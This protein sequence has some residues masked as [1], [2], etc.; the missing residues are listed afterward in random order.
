MLCYSIFGPANSFAAPCPPYNPHNLSVRDFDGDGCADAIDNCQYVYNPL[1][2]DTDPG[3]GGDACDSYGG[4]PNPVT[5]SFTESPGAGTVIYERID[6]CFAL[7][8]EIL[9]ADK[10]TKKVAD[11]RSGDMVWNPLL[12]KAAQVKKV[13]RGPEPIPLYHIKTAH[14]SLSVTKSHPFVTSEGI[15][16]TEHLKVGNKV[17]D[18]DGSFAKVTSV[19][20]LPVVDGQLVMNFELESDSNDV[21]HHAIVANGIVTGDLFLQTGSSSPESH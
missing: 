18:A 3:P 21:Q 1:Q 5:I 16:T 4:N 10:T 14:N 15:V 9:M 11:I 12:K 17:Q 2:E 20:K 19:S 8:V 6:G 7:D 13:V